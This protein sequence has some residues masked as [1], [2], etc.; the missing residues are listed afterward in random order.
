MELNQARGQGNK[1]K[2]NLPFSYIWF[3][4][5]SWSALYKLFSM[6]ISFAND[7]LCQAHNYSVK[8]RSSICCL[9]FCLGFSVL[10]VWTKQFQT[11]KAVKN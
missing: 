5:W 6:S 9:S 2:H 10:N 7:Q 4:E 8:W 3:D 1:I 11:G